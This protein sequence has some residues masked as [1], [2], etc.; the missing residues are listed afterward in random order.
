MRDRGHE[1]DESIIESGKSRLRPVL[2]TALT[3]ILGMLPLAL[4]TGE[5]SEIWSPMGIAV[6]YRFFAS[7]VER[8]K[9]KEVRSK[10]VFMDI[11]NLISEK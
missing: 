3:T 7:K 11:Y 6:F 2:M 9:Q 10:F 8:N 4:S 1:L 5:S